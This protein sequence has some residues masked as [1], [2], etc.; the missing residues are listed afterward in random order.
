MLRENVFWLSTLCA[1]E[2][3][4]LGVSAARSGGR[5]ERQVGVHVARAADRV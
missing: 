5:H 4:A 1:V 2:H 3:I